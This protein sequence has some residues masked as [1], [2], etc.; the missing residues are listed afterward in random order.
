MGLRKPSLIWP[1]DMVPPSHY[2]YIAAR[3]PPSLY[4]LPPSYLTLVAARQP[5]RA[6]QTGAGGAREW[7]GYVLV[8]PPDRIFFKMKT[9]LWL[10]SS[11][12]LSTV[13]LQDED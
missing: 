9:S 13:Y 6:S 11:K 1:H 4:P 2:L 8:H 3:L 5:G 7:E 10:G 12:R